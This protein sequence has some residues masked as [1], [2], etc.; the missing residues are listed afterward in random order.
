MV[1]AMP[2]EPATQAAVVAEGRAFMLSSLAGED[3]IRQS[4]KLDFF[5]K[6]Q[7]ECKGLH[8]RGIALQGLV[9]IHSITNWAA[10]RGFRCGISGLG[11]LCS[12][13]DL[14]PQDPIINC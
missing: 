5:S 6:K 14:Y 11:R 9:N 4:G 1:S 10:E 3:L 13:Q 12:P 8:L 7:T 2:S